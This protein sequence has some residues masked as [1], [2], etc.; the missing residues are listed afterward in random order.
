[1]KWRNMKVHFVTA[2]STFSEIKFHTFPQVYDIK[3]DPA[4]KLRALGQR[5]IL[6][7]LVDDPRY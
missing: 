1:M 3:E 4:G 2:E 5:G 6:A 7:R